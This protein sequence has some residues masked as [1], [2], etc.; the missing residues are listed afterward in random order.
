MKQR[1]THNLV[2]NFRIKAQ[3][4]YC[5]SNLS[6]L[7]KRTANDYFQQLKI[8]LKLNISARKNEAGMNLL[9]LISSNSIFRNFGPGNILLFKG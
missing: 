8:F 2:F 6:L 5:S 4:V 1:S 9:L 7:D 3:N